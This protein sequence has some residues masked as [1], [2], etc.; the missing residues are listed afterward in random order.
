MDIPKHEPPEANAGYDAP[1]EVRRARGPARRACTPRCASLIPHLRPHTARH[2]TP[3]AAPEL[4]PPLPLQGKAGEQAAMAVQ[5]KMN[6]QT[7]PIRTYLDSTVVPVLLQGLS[8]L[9]KE[10][11]ARATWPHRARAH[12]PPSSP[13]ARQRFTRA[14]FD[15][16]GPRTRSST[17]PP[18]SCRTTRPRSECACRLVRACD[19]RVPQPGAAHGGRGGRGRAAARCASLSAGCRRRPPAASAVALGARLG[20]GSVRTQRISDRGSA[21]TTSS[22]RAAPDARRAAPV[23]S[24]SLRHR[25]LGPSRI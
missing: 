9:V 14:R 16:A 23:P 15:V 20:T 7:A 17:S 24:A 18:S 12:P 3:P 13:A 10:R 19:V 2:P 5:S 8:A 1:E 25:I 22:R 11:C 6:L 21:A 4:P